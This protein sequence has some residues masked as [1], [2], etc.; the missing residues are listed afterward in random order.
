MQTGSNAQPESKP[1]LL[2]LPAFPT[3]S[4]FV[5]NDE[6]SDGYNGTGEREFR[7]TPQ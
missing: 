3:R 7:G 2:I 6:F 5:G 4:K 1:E